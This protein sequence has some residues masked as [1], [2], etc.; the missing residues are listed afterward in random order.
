MV[1]EFI[2]TEGDIDST[3]DLLLESPVNPYK[4]EITAITM[5]KF[6]AR[7]PLSRRPRKANPA[8]ADAPP[9]KQ[10]NRKEFTEEQSRSVC[11]E[12]TKFKEFV[13]LRGPNSNIPQEKFSAKEVRKLIQFIDA[14]IDRFG[15]CGVKEA[16]CTGGRV[17]NDE[18]ECRCPPGYRW[19]PA[20][21]LSEVE[22][23]VIP[24][25]AEG[26]CVKNEEKP[27]EK[28]KAKIGDYKWLEPQRD[29][30]V[31]WLAGFK[32]KGSLD[33]S[34]GPLKA[35]VIEMFTF[36]RLGHALIKKGNQLS[37]PPSDKEKAKFFER[38]IFPKG[39]Q[40]EILTKALQAMA[41]TKSGGADAIADAKELFE[42]L[43][44]ALQHKKKILDT[45]S[46]LAQKFNATKDEYLKKMYMLVKKI[47]TSDDA[48]A[49]EVPKVT[50]VNANNLATRDADNYEEGGKLLNPTGLALAK[51]QI[52][53]LKDK[54][55]P[56]PP[57]LAKA[58]AGEVTEGLQSD[59][60][61][62]QEGMLHSITIDF[63]E[64]R[65]KQKH[66]DESFLVMFGGWVKWLLG[67]MF[68]GGSIPG[69]IKGSRS[70]VESFARAMGS[71]KRYIET[72]K[73][74]GL[75]H[76]TTYKSKA[77]LSS[78]TKGFEKE[79][80]IKWPFE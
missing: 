17:K 79:T 15:F 16:E 54:G 11:A 46:G 80:G 42:D 74:Y 1:K 76:P 12:L 55:K 72:A 60:N 23:D 10:R 36:N 29:G 21:E 63:S 51:A 22:G 5:G 27:A 41:K 77:K 2:I 30:S 53:F 68:D 7:N 39:E 32:F 66:L 49:P 78:A 4:K 40:L 33:K 6:L 52:A 18:G 35:M 31:D 9:P 37:Q 34:F 44:K 71:E 67:K 20:K 70:E 69:T 50:A 8:F 25:D 59:S 56:V 13:K 48:I 64:I 47:E 19:E 62:L 45:D 43:L 75:D 24:P 14:R 3:L 65:R 57:I 38:Y 58:A 61:A 28:V 73:R 26:K